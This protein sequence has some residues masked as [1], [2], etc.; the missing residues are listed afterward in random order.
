MISEPEEIL[1]NAVQVVVGTLQNGFEL[2]D[3]KLVVVTE[4]ELYNQQPKR[5]ARHQTL[6]NA[7]RLRSY[8]ELT[9]GDYVVHVNHGIGQYVGMQI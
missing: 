9:P 8:T 7:E 4:H 6:A 3:S 2:P 5:H 1:P